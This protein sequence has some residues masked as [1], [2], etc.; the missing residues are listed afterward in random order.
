MLFSIV[1]GSLEPALSAYGWFQVI[2]SFISDD[3][4]QCFDLQFTT[5]HFMQILLKTGPALMYWKVE[6][7]LLQSRPAFLYHKVRKVVLQNRAGITD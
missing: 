6:Q 3:I 1:R 2:P 5:N 7:M 4:R